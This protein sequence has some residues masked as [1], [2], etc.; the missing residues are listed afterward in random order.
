MRRT[1]WDLDHNRRRFIVRKKASYPR[2]CCPIFRLQERERKG[3]ARS[4][5]ST[6]LPGRVADLT[7]IPRL[8]FTLLQ[9]RERDE[10]VRVCVMYATRGPGCCVDWGRVWREF[11][12]KW[13]ISALRSNKDES[14]RAERR[15][16]CRYFLVM[17]P[18]VVCGKKSVETTIL[19]GFFPLWIIFL[20]IENG[21][22]LTKAIRK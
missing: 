8:S 3:N 12:V 11:C 22:L 14:R 15:F 17:L 1:V 19:L 2:G 4:E 20:I 18:R 7:F 5:K 10:R 9:V 16:L 13:R 6:H 21:L